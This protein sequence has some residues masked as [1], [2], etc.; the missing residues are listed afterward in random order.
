MDMEAPDYKLYAFCRRNGAPVTSPISDTD[1]TLA[2]LLVRQLIAQLVGLE[3]QIEVCVFHDDTGI[4]GE[5]MDYISNLCVTARL[6][7]RLCQS[8]PEITH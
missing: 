4:R 5:A 6:E 1:R 3:Q 2:T 7:T 8:A